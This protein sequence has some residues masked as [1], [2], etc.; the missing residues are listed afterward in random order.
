MPGP[1][2]CHCTALPAPGGCYIMLQ[3]FFSL[4]LCFCLSVSTASCVAG[5]ASCLAPLLGL[6]PPPPPPPSPPPPPRLEE[7]EEGEVGEEGGD[8]GG[9]VAPWCCGLR[10]CGLASASPLSLLA[11]RLRSSAR[12]PAAWRSLPPFHSCRISS[13]SWLTSPSGWKGL[14]HSPSSRRLQR[15][16]V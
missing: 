5:A 13:A 11:A 9:S 12:E 2:Q 15:R 3:C 6:P 4:F 14:S 10:C 8:D 7:G 16:I 1:P